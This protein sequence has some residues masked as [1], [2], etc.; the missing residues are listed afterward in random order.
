M[1]GRQYKTLEQ[2]D[3]ITI[4]SGNTKLGITEAEYDKRL[5]EEA[6]GEG[7]FQRMVRE[8]H[9]T[10]QGEGVAM[11]VEEDIVWEQYAIDAQG[12]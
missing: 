5:M 1:T 4:A 3:A 2:L 11:S 10:G 7:M 6:E 9:I 12:V 8:E